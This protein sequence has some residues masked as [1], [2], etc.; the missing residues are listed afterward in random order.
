MKIFLAHKKES[1]LIC[2]NFFFKQEPLNK[3]MNKAKVLQ[4]MVLRLP[5]YN[6]AKAHPAVRKIQN[7][8]SQPPKPLTY[9]L[10]ELPENITDV[11]DVITPLGTHQDIPFHVLSIYY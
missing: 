9:K 6:A 4:S 3:K 8:M 10:Q 7:R 2:F 1:S 5:K 11:A